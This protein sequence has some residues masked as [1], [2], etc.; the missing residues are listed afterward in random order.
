M[1]QDLEETGSLRSPRCVDMSKELGTVAPA[2]EGNGQE[3][4]WINLV[5]HAGAHDVRDKAVS[6]V[7]ERRLLHAP[8]FMALYT[9]PLS[10]SERQKALALPGQHFLGSSR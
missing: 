9:A 7:G 10:P 2:S 4:Y 3:G 6:A 5:C 8:W 1:M